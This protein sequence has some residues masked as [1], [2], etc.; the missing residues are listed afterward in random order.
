MKELPPYR[1]LWE[2]SIKDFKDIY[3]WTGLQKMLRIRFR[4]HVHNF[5]GFSDMC[6]T[7]LLNTRRPLSLSHQ[8]GGHSAVLSL[9]L[10]P[11]AT[12]KSRNAQEKYKPSFLSLGLRLSEEKSKPH[13]EW[14]QTTAPKI[15]DMEKAGDQTRC[16]E[17]RWNVAFT[18]TA[19][20]VR[21]FTPFGD[22]AKRAWGPVP[23]PPAPFWDIRESF[24]KED[25]KTKS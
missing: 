8:A 6:Q 22:K 3:W 13:S 16:S 10:N 9:C 7:D 18:S 2:K 4:W 21:H 19:H 15:K 24:L 20:T 14:A 1:D 5:K 23:G 12:D 17:G 11:G 25:N